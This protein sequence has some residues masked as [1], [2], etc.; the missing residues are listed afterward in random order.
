MCCG[1][2]GFLY[3][4]VGIFLF[5]YAVWLIFFPIMVVSRIDKIIKL[6]EKKE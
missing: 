6:L 4:F 2:S 3:V 5:I 1:L